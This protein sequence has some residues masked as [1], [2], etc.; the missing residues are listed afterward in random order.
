MAKLDSKDL[1]KKGKQELSKL[2]AEKEEA[3]HKF[4]FGVAGSKV[5]NIKDGKNIKKDIARIKTAMRLS[6]NK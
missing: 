5:K 4:R 2:V 1:I 6:E 3:L